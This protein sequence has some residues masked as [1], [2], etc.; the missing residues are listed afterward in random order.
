VKWVFSDGTE[1]T[2][3]GTVQGTGPLADAIRRDVSRASAGYRVHVQVH[4]HPNPPEDLDLNDAQLVHEWLLALGVRHDIAL[5][6]APDIEPIESPEYS[7]DGDP[8]G[9]IY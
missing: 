7:T 1:Y 4:V 2:M 3:A 5:T 9:A 8:P 6:S